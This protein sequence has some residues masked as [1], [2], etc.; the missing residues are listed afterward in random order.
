MRISSQGSAGDIALNVTTT[1]VAVL[2]QDTVYDA[3]VKTAGQTF[4]LGAITIPQGKA[5]VTVGAAPGDG[6]LTAAASGPVKPSA[7]KSARLTWTT[8]LS[9]A[10]ATSFSNR[11]PRKIIA[12]R[13]AHSFGT[14]PHFYL[15]TELD[16]RQM[17]SLRQQLL[18]RLSRQRRE[19]E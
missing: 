8:K 17:V 18:P 6:T 11:G 9:L 19:N 2:K 16:A 13:M 7:A 15:H 5:G 3:T 10:I 1:R 4:R 14:A 12:E